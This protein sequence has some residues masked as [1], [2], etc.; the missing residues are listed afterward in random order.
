VHTRFRNSVAPGQRARRLLEHRAPEWQDGKTGP[1]LDATD[2]ASVEAGAAGM[3]AWT[4]DERRLVDASRREEEQRKARETRRKQVL[5]NFVYA[6]AGAFVVSLVAL[7]FAWVQWGNATTNERVAKEQTKKAQDEEAEAREQAR[8]AAQR[9]RFANAQWIAT[10]SQ[11]AFP[12][13]P[14]QCL[15]LAVEAVQATRKGEV[16]VIPAAE[17]A[18][19]DAVSAFPGRPLVGHMGSISAL[20]F[21]P[22][23]RLV[24][25]SGDSTARV[26]DLKDPTAQPL[27][28]RGHEGSISVLAFA[29]D[30][31]LVTGS[32]DKTARVWD[33]KD[34]TAQPLV[35][36]GHEGSIE[37]L[38]F[39][40]D[41]RLVTGSDDKTARVWDLNNPLAPPVVLRG[42][43]SSIGALALAPDGRLIAAAG[44]RILIWTLDPKQLI[45][46][47]EQ[48]AG[49]N[50]SAE[51]WQQFFN[52][53]PYRR[54]FPKLPDGEGVAEA[55]KE[56]RLTRSDNPLPTDSPIVTH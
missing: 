27:V 13:K 7:G 33:L 1:A 47:A 37:A 29:P 16:P 17:Q 42:V 49:R 52:G 20:A 54:T 39:A 21:A 8:L 19:H 48:S 5:R 31:R 15:I 12:T 40:P 38:R 45:R 46:M 36:R 11:A 30:G 50:L 14:Q 10:L 2:L 24:T 51:E 26:W 53:Q 25:G 22:D 34:P 23:G 32:D 9:E 4:D 28:L 56:G 44:D 18:L 55:L 35:L 43:G 41:G 3:R 6:L